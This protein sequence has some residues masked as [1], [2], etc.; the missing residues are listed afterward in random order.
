M[1][2][3]PS[4]VPPTVPPHGWAAALAVVLA[5]L[6]SML[7][8]AA[9]GLWAAGA[10]GLPGDAFGRVTAATVVTAV[11]GSMRLAGN[12]GA[13]AQT[14]AGITVMPLSVT[15]VGALVLGAGFLRPLRGRVALGAREPAG[16]AVRIAVLWLAGLAGLA[17]AAR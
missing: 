6:V 8:V 7:A 2:P 17:F 11:G 4:S 13:L 5:A 9:L 14:H 10:T 1:S 15:L 3:P 12:A 16:W